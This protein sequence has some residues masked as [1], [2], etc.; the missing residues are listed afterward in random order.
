M[1]EIPIQKPDILNISPG[2]HAPVA[3]E[4]FS[5]FG[6]GR[7]C[8]TNSKLVDKALQQKRNADIYM[9]YRHSCNR[10]I[11]Y[12]LFT[13]RVAIMCK[14]IQT[15]GESECLYLY[16]DTNCTGILKITTKTCPKLTFRKLQVATK[17]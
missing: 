8:R 15:Q 10:Y 3:S 2:R 16:L 9:N 14:G 7:I 5:V 11:L 1:Q 13:K 12:I 17:R 6:P 4:K